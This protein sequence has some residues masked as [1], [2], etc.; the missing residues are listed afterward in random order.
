MTSHLSPLATIRSV[1]VN[2]PGRLATLSKRGFRAECPKIKPGQKVPLTQSEKEAMETEA[3]R[4]SAR[5]NPP[6]PPLQGRPVPNLPP[7]PQP[8]PMD[9]SF[10]IQSRRLDAPISVEPA[11]GQ[12]SSK[13]QEQLSS[14]TSTTESLPS[15]SPLKTPFKS[16]KSALKVL[17]IS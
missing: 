15:G 8:M 6:L 3:L 2:Y 11:P 10:S 5:V 7:P 12:A 16:R 17:P 4:M 9:A 14:A 13:P 1:P